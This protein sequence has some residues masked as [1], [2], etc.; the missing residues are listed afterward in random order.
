MVAQPVEADSTTFTTTDVQVSKPIDKSLTFP[1]RKQQGANNVSTI[2]EFLGKPRRLLSGNWTPASGNNTELQ[3]FRSFDVSQMPAAISSKLLGFSG[4]R[5]TTNIKLVLN[6]TPFQAGKLAL[7]YYPNGRQT[8]S[9]MALHTASRIALSQLPGGEMTTM[10][11]ALEI[12]IPFTSYQEYYELAGSDQRDP[13]LFTLRVFSPLV[14]GPAATSPNAGY[15][16]WIWYTDVE[17]FG[18]SSAVPQSAPLKKKGA[19]TS[20]EERPLSTWLSASSKLASS[21]SSIPII[22]GISG[23]SAVWLKMASGLAHSLG[24]SRPVDSE[25]IRTMAPHYM[26]SVPNCD[27][28][29]NSSVLAWNR[30][31]RARLITDYSPSGMDETSVAFIKRQWSFIGDIP[32][33]TADADAAELMSIRLA[34]GVSACRGGTPFIP[35]GGEVITGAGTSLASIDFLAF[36]T[37]HYRGGLELCFKFVKTGFHSGSIQFSYDINRQSP[38]DPVPAMTLAATAPLHRTIVDIQDGESVCLAF[39]FVSQADFLETYESFGRCRVHVVNR[40]VAPE[41]V[42]S[43]VVIQ[44]YVRGMED[45]EFTGISNQN[46]LQPSVREPVI[47]PQGMD[48]EKSDEIICQPIGDALAMQDQSGIQMMDSMSESI[49][50]LLQFAKMGNHISFRTTNSNPSFIFNPSAWTTATQNAAGTQ[51]KAP[52]ALCNIMQAIRGCYAYQRGGY[53]INVLPPVSTANLNGNV[54]AWTDYN[55]GTPPTFETNANDLD[56]EVTSFGAG[57]TTREFGFKSFRTSNNGKYGL[58]ITIPYKNRYRVSPIYPHPQTA[59]VNSVGSNGTDF[60]DRTRV[61]IGANQ[62]S[63]ILLRGAEDYQLLYWVGVPCFV[64]RTF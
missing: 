14:N 9:K 7:R 59:G 30:D 38:N 52:F 10:E 61:G 31:A 18:A 32:W 57:I 56:F 5:F 54:Y 12:K 2:L 29:S 13:I 44:V 48:V 42:P 16:V 4:I 27:G 46:G 50:S 64:V 49:T 37:R 33:S 63:A 24:Y 15:S 8:Q 28:L 36:L 21:L 60:T 40:L 6:A 19:P 22:S 55:F 23:P 39:P 34:P 43:S 53:E 58:S 11:K 47:V 25:P 17:L 3:S 51:Q 26:V 35:F 1:L 62:Q 45:L 20:E 41:T